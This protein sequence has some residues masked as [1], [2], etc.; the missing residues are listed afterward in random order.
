MNIYFLADFLAW[1][2]F[3]QLGRAQILIWKQEEA[4]QAP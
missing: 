1:S 4:S 3:G 2:Y